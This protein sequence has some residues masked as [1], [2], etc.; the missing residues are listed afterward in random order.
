MVLTMLGSP[1]CPSSGCLLS[2]A[3]SATD[4]S[5]GAPT[6]E[7]RVAQEALETLQLEKRLSL[8]SHPGRPG[9]GGRARPGL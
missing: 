9:S 2:D 3:P 1:C 8:L 4:P 5:P 6:V 7:E